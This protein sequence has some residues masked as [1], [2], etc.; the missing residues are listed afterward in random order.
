MRV[1]AFYSRARCARTL[2]DLVGTEILPESFER[3]C[4]HD[5]LETE[6]CVSVRMRVS[7]SYSRAR[8]AR[9]L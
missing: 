6:Y 8:C 7:A 4:E 5:K 2:D 3:F 9:M 1:S